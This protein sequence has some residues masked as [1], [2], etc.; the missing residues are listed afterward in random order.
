[1]RGAVVG[2]TL[3]LTVHA[4]SCTSPPPQAA[5]RAEPARPAADFAVRL[6]HKGCRYEYLDT[7]NGT[8]GRRKRVPFILSAE[9]RDTL[10]AAV[11]AADFFDRPADLGTGKDP[12]G[13]FELEVRNAGRRHT[14]KWT[15][16]SRWGQSE[17]A[18]PLWHLQASIFRVLEN[19]FGRGGCGCNVAK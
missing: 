13:N 11:M 16:E 14:V 6:D 8:F 1:M 15:A 2:A 4:A 5:R 12:T 19:H 17:D 3:F 18:I 10:F 9:E 7:F